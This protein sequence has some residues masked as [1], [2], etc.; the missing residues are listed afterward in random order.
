MEHALNLDE[1][2]LQFFASFVGP[3]F[4]PTHLDPR[5]GRFKIEKFERRMVDGVVQKT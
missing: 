1:Y 5:I 4:E 3:K 2:G